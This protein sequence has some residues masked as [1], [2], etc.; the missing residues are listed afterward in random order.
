MCCLPMSLET[1]N[2]P[3]PS[4]HRAHAF[5]L[6]KVRCG[7]MHLAETPLGFRGRHHF[8][9]RHRSVNDASL[10]EHHALETKRARHTSIASRWAN[11]TNKT[12]APA[13]L[14]S[15]LG[16]R[17][18]PLRRRAAVAVTCVPAH[19][20]RPRPRGLGV[21]V[22]WRG[23]RCADRGGIR[24]GRVG[25][26]RASLRRAFLRGGGASLGA[27]LLRGR[28]L[29]RF[30]RVYH[31]SRRRFRCAGTCGFDWRWRSKRKTIVFYKRNRLRQVLRANFEF[32]LLLTSRSPA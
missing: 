3:G 17:T 31:S 22:E 7:N 21:G 4:T 18:P 19:H 29:L 23:R 14:R 5:C 16:D 24:N 25:R 27:R 28:R 11:I 8:F 6:N 9:A 20:T 12:S 1:R 13:P 2:P 26:F 10:T 30:F 32:P 15:I